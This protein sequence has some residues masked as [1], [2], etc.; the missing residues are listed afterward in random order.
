MRDIPKYVKS[1]TGLV[2]EALQVN[3]ETVDVISNW[4]SARII[5]ETDPISGEK[6]EALNVPTPDGTKRASR[7]NYVVKM[8]GRFFVAPG[9]QFERMYQPVQEPKSVI[10]RFQKLDSTRT[11]LGFGGAKII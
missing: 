11:K 5:E 10:D 1:Q 7:G 6:L 3:E 9:Q 4:A 2:V 8:N